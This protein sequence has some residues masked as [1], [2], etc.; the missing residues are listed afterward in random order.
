MMTQYNDITRF[1]TISKDKPEV[2]TLFKILSWISL[3][4]LLLSL[5]SL[6]GCQSTPVE[7]ERTGND[8]FKTTA[9]SFIYY[10]NI[11]SIKY[12]TNRNPKTQ[13]DFYRPKVFIKSNNISTIYP[14]IIH[15]W[16]EDESYLI[17]EKRNIGEDAKILVNTAVEDTILLDWPT[18]DYLDQLAF[19]RQLE[20]TLKSGENIF[21]QEIGR[22]KEVLNY[23]LAE[24]KSFSTTLQDFLSLTET[25]SSRAIK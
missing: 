21:I 24:R 13:M 15:N 18:K 6:I 19:V 23:S 10:K 17:F 20:Q 25:A 4:I 12:Q 8:R 5:I 22:E 11:K 14:V 2:I 3:N 7:R 9:P 16:L 1:F